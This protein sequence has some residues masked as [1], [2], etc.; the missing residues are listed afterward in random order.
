MKASKIK[1][2]FGSVLGKLDSLE[3]SVLSLKTAVHSAAAARP[4]ICTVMLFAD[5]H[6]GQ[7]WY[8]AESFKLTHGRQ[9]EVRFAPQITLE[10]GGWL[11]GFGG[12]LLSGAR[13][14]DR[15]CD[16]VSSQGPIA[17]ITHACSPGLH[18][19]CVATLDVYGGNH[20]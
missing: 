18:I 12:V 17:R 16:V 10:P 6:G 13:V 8:A 4:R 5:A 15:A 3:H 11:V 7:Q 9:Y 14:G 1:Q 19:R 20:D 2:L